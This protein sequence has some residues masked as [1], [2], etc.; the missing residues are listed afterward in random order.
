[1][2]R[3]FDLFEDE[4]G[5]QDYKQ[6]VKLA[7]GT[8]SSSSSG[9]DLLGEDLRV[10]EMRPLNIEGPF[11]SLRVVCQ[12]K[13]PPMSRGRGALRLPRALGQQLVRFSKHCRW[14]LPGGAGHGPPALPMGAT[15]A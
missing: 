15:S 10:F 6:W 13:A 12:S 9:V 14:G 7:C 2:L 5:T 11:L 3:K 4:D 8:V 1:M